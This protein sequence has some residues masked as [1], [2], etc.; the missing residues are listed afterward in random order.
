MS[1]AGRLNGIVL[2]GL[3]AASLAAGQD[4][5]S[6]ADRAEIRGPQFHGPPSSEEFEDFSSPAIARLRKEYRLDDVV[7]GETSEFQKQ[8]K[9]RH[10][11]HSRWPI[12]NDQKFSGDV[13]AILGKAKT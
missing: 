8:L 5:A 7:R 13:F 6:Q 11:V 10:W 4:S 12:D 9:L 2:F 1:S 3:L